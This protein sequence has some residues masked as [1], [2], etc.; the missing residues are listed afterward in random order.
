[1][2]EVDDCFD[3]T[4]NRGSKSASSSSSPNRDDAEGSVFDGMFR[5]GDFGVDCLEDCDCFGDAEGFDDDMAKRGLTSS[6]SSSPNN[7]DEESGGDFAPIFD[8]DLGCFEEA[9]KRV[10]SSSSSFPPNNDE[11]SAGRLFV[12]TVFGGISSSVLMGSTCVDSVGV[13]SLS[14]SVSESPFGFGEAPNSSALSFNTSPNGVEIVKFGFSF[15]EP[16]SLSAVDF[17]SVSAGT[18]SAGNKVER[19][20]SAASSSSCFILSDLGC[21][22]VIWSKEKS[23]DFCSSFAP[24]SE[25][26]P[27]SERNDFKTGLGDF[28]RDS[29]GD[30][31][32]DGAGDTTDEDGRGDADG[33]ADGDGAADSTGDAN[34]ECRGD[35]DI[36]G[37]GDSDGGENGVTVDSNIADCS[38][39]VKISGLN[40][41]GTCELGSVC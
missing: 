33:D 12:S 1:M 8:D 23:S 4:E 7:D 35:C 19:G 25:S 38:G 36:D 14:T 20:P 6:S 34:G 32:G 16:N 26:D 13:D 3:G 28:R 31:S 39:T 2:E 9:E 29:T 10:S 17:G 21:S 41:E 30:G 22:F 5:L 18:G 11:T 27:S 24:N 40:K 37:G 15:T